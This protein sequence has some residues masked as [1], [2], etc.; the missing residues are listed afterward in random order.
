MRILFIT[1]ELPFPLTNGYLRYFHFLRALSQHHT[2]T[3]FSLTRQNSV[4][5]EA[6]DAL[7]P[8]ADD[9][10]IFGLPSSGEPYRV[11]AA[12]MLGARAQRCVR[13]HDAVRQLKSA[14]AETVARTN[15][16]VI[17][18][19]GKE[20]LAAVDQALPVPL[21]IDCCD[22]DHVRLRREIAHAGIK[23]IFWRL[24]RYLRFRHAEKKILQMTPDIIFVSHR[25]RAALMGR[26]QRGVVIPQAVDFAY[27][28]RARERQLQ[29]MLVFS[30]SMKYEPN[31]DAAMLLVNKIFPKIRAKFPSVTLA[32][33]GR[34]PLPALLRGARHV[35]G[36][37]VTGTVADVRPYLAQ[38]SVF[39]APLR[40][41][42]GMQNKVLE[43]MSMEL[44]VVTTTPVYEGLSSE[45]AKPPVVISDLQGFADR[46]C[47]L[48]RDEQLRAKLASAGRRYVQSH[49]NW[50]RS[51]DALELTLLRA[52]AM[53]RQPWSA[54][55]LGMPTDH[56][57][58]ATNLSC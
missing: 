54:S 17:F 58:C 56:E 11:K 16:D 12:A 38:A 50:K 46:V 26:S 29:N 51:Y 28:S 4:S 1:P 32:L 55:H 14:V 27:W 24:G 19:C 3:C 18:L 13:M 36:V 9:I 47:D 10:Q 57:R 33:V 7:N 8:L 25:D 41:A 22:A 53:Y 52:V 42:S 6:W 21:V 40:F 34:D 5:P 35:D 43:A 45:G 39:V 23:E 37:T 2:I 20:A 31:H 49:C 48:L 30:G 44:P 15:C